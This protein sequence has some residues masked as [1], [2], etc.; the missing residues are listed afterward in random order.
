[1]IY[2]IHLKAL[3]QMCPN[4]IFNITPEG[5]HE[6]VGKIDESQP[7]INPTMDELNAWI[8]EN[9]PS[10]AM[11]ELR[12]QRNKLL[13]ESDKMYQPDRPGATAWATYRQ[14]LRDLPQSVSPEVDDNLRLTNIDWPTK[15]E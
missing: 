8:Q 4:S 6:F 15:P 3:E 13:E 11:Q 10:L 7:A 9:R 14:A 5:R 1:V 2:I 12:E